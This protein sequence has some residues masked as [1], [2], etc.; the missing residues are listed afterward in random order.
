MISLR[1]I[2]TVEPCVGKWVLHVLQGFGF[3]D[4]FC[5]FYQVLLSN[6]AYEIFFIGK[7]A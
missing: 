2:Q 3:F 5:P 4:F 6:A 1:R 7:I